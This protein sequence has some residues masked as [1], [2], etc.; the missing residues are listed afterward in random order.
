MTKTDYNCLVILGPTAAGKTHLGVRLAHAYAGEIISADSRQVYRGLDIGAGKDL[1]E[2]RLGDTRIAA[3]LI[4]II[5]LD[6]EYNVFDF[7]QDFY[8]VFSELRAKK[9]LP[10]LVGGTGLYLDSVLLGYEMAKIPENPERRARL[11]AMTAEELEAELRALKPD[12]H[13]VT[14]LVSQERMIQAIEIALAR[15]ENPPPPRPELRPLVLGTRWDREQLRSRIR[16][17][18]SQRLDEG[19][20]EEVEALHRQGVSWARL[21]SLGL[22]YR[23]VSNFL[24]GKLESR[25]QLNE[26]LAIA[27]SQFARRQRRWFRRME[28]RGIQIHWVNEASLTEAAQ[29]MQSAFGPPLRNL[30][31]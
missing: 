15:A 22:E 19:L 18:L 25:D 3:H 20:I 31:D 12:L 30:I 29:V 26:L 24:T 5:D 21:D 23:F 28:R 16:I 11:Q 2:Y 7:Q 1:E 17:R 9:V 27:I 4:D 10:V 6:Q 8:R 14:D 13:N